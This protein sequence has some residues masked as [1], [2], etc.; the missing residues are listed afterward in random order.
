MEILVCLEGDNVCM[1]GWGATPWCCRV[2]PEAHSFPMIEIAYG[3]GRRVLVKATVTLGL[4]NN[5]IASY[6][7]RPNTRGTQF[8][9][10]KDI[11]YL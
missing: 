6:D 2:M 9:I 3:G 4:L 10:P 11:S 8:A 7:G 5:R 1:V